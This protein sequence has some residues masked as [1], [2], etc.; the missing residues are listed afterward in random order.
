MTEV[1]CKSIHCKWN[2]KKVCCKSEITLGSMSG[3]CRD[4]EKK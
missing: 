4:Y 3:R 1:N 2:N